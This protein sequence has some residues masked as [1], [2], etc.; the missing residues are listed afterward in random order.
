ME[1]IPAAPAMDFGPSGG[2]GFKAFTIEEDINGRPT[3][4]EIDSLHKLRQVERES[5]VR[6]RN[7]EGRPLVWRDYAQQRTN[8]DVH[9]LSANPADPHGALDAVKRAKA[10]KITAAKGDAVTSVH[11]TI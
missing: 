9:T 1:P 11:G 2:T 7:G 6:A 5:E 10:A 4:I 3:T 8:G